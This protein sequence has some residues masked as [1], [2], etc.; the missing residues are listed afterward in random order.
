MDNIYS[1][2][3]S[4]DDLTCDI[5]KRSKTITFKNDN[6]EFSLKFKVRKGIMEIVPGDNEIQSL[7]LSNIIGKAGYN[8]VNDA[9]DMLSTIKDTIKNITNYCVSC[10]E[11]MEFQSD[12]FITC[13]SEECDY[14]YE[15]IVIGN[16]VID[17][18]KL[19]EQIVIFLIES[20]INAMTCQRKF[21]IFEPFPK[22]F[23]TGDIDICRGQVSKL[24]GNNFDSYKD[25]TKLANTIKDFTAGDF[26]NIASTCLDDKEL[27]K[28]I[29]MDKYML[30]RFIILSCKTDLVKDEELLREHNFKGVSVYKIRHPIDKDEDFNKRSLGNTCYLFHGS[31]WSNWYSI[32]RN[33]L[34]NCSKTKLMTAG[35][36]Y[37]NGI[38]LSDAASLSLG[39]GRSGNKYVMGV[40][41]V[42]G[43]KQ[44]YCKGGNVFVCDDE[45]RLRQKYLFICSTYDNRYI[46]VLNKLCGTEIKKEENKVTVTVSSK[47]VKRLVRE[48][49]K[50]AK[51]KQEDLGFRIV[52]DKTNVYLWK[53][54]IFGFDKDTPLGKDMEAIGCNEIETEIIFP[55]AYPMAPPFIRIVSPRFQYQTG[56]VTSA[57]ALCMQILTDKYWA[58]T[59]SMESLIINIKSEIIEGGGRIDMK[60]WKIPY[61]EREA[62]E[63]FIRVSR[64]HGWA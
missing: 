17:A 51:Q 9:F 3:E 11:R 41:E 39:Y 2:V 52:P 50:I 46:S 30:I 20:A 60:N 47:G 25:F 15:E 44:T 28:T 16:P 31:N 21:D 14:R 13:G 4:F 6:T 34:K 33:G 61:G 10:C 42:I 48:Y 45:T 43:T 26:I 1:L 5:N 63:S 37:G 23:L 49:K 55:T 36:A 54:Y 12:R 53:M 27:I 40:F 8:N 35:A 32:L 62:R 56:H 59:C 18:I 24:A 22:Y 64:G 38:Y 19:D 57:G 29:G 7:M 58:A